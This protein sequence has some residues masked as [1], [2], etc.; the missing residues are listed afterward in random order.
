MEYT[1]SI[2]EMNRRKN[3]FRTLSIS[4]FLSVSLASL[5]QFYSS[6]QVVVISLSVLA[7]TL[8]I[9]N[10]LFY[11]LFE[12]S[13]LTTIILTNSELERKS[14]KGHDKWRFSDICAVRI[15][16]TSRD[17]IREIR[18]KTLHSGSVYINGLEG[19]ESFANDLIKALSMDESP[20]QIKEL[21]DYDHSLFYAVFGA[22]LGLISVLS[23]KTIQSLQIMTIAYLQ[24]GVACF[25]LFVALFWFLER[26]IAGRYG[27]KTTCI[28]IIISTFMFLTCLYMIYLSKIWQMIGGRK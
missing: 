14:I 27:Q 23:V 13:K 7:L 11:R 16:W 10:L 8:L 28:D 19:F 20:Y 17:M 18:L 25:I 9:S 1:T 5:I 3:A 24:F 21:I 6:F 26:P 15:K 22:I 2:N 4:F 12:E